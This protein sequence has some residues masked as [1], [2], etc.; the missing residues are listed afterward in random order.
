MVGLTGLETTAVT[1][2]RT[3]ALCNP[4]TEFQVLTPYASH[5]DS[6][7]E[8][9]RADTTSDEALRKLSACSLQPNVD[10]KVCRRCFD[11]IQHNKSSN[12]V[13]LKC[14]QGANR[15]SV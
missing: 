13:V 12:A 6:L 4:C 2:V 9:F 15:S 14:C 10:C 8:P 5:S 1:A 7:C 3:F 11:V